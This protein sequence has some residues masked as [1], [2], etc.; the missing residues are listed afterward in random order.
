MQVNIFCSITEPNLSDTYEPERQEQPYHKSL[1]SRRRPTT[2]DMVLSRYRQ[3]IQADGRVSSTIQAISE[4]KLV[5]P[6]LEN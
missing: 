6:I 4:K 3:T 2:T 5:P 1:E